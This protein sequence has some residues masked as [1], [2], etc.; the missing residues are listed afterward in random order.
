MAVYVVKLSNM[1]PNT[2]VLS[3][4]Q[5]SVHYHIILFVTENCT[6]VT[7]QKHI[8]KKLKSILCKQKLNAKFN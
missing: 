2:K 3:E 8:L 1:Y 4:K 6:H 7:L 5:M